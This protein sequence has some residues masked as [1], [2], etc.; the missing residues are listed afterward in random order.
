VL[1]HTISNTS[2]LGSSLATSP[3]LS[4]PP[5]TG[6]PTLSLGPPPP[7]P[8]YRRYAASALLFPNTG[9]PRDHRESLNFFPHL[10]LAA[11]E[12]PRRNLISTDRVSCVAR[13]RTQLQRFKTF[14]GPICRK[15]EPP[16]Q[17]SQ[18]VK[19][20]GNCKKNP[21]MAKQILLYS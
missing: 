14:Q 21:K 15:L 12:P 18:L 20:I 9:H 17:I 16:N 1:Q 13:P 5:A 19:S 8:V 2:S 10:P 3:S 11:G 4:C 6:T 7:A